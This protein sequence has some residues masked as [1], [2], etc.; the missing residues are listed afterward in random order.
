MITAVIVAALLQSAAINAKRD[1]FLSCL[2][3]QVAAAVKG[4]S[5][6]AETFEAQ[7][8]ESCAASA[9][10]MKAELV[11]FD[12]KNKVPRKQAAED[13][14]LQI[15]DFLSTSVSQYK[16]KAAAPK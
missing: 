8:R 15:D 6:A 1:A 2:D 12:V 3:Q 11:A 9:D 7:A 16:K 14:Q 5:I 10:A 13:A 4:Q